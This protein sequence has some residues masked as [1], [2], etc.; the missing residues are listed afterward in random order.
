MG[1][2]AKKSTV[3]VLEEL[4]IK[5]SNNSPYWQTYYHVEGKTFR[6][7]TKCKDVEQAKLVAAEWFYDIKRDVV[8]GVSHTLKEVRHSSIS[9]WLLSTGAFVPT[10]LASLLSLDSLAQC[11][12]HSLQFV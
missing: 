2:S 1:R 8:A 5:P 3:E 9:A 10:I 12:W 7:S 11:S 6:K 4:Y